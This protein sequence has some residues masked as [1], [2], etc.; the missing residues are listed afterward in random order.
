MPNVSSVDNTVSKTPESIKTK[1]S[2]MYDTQRRA[3]N[4]DTSDSP[5]SIFQIKKL[6]NR[7]T[8]SQ[9]R[10]TALKYYPQLNRTT[11]SQIRTTESKHY[12]EVNRGTM[13]QMQSTA[14]KHY[15][16]MNRATM[17]QKRGIVSKHN[18]GVNGSKSQISLTPSKRCPEVNQVTKSQIPVIKPKHY[19][20]VT[21]KRGVCH[22]CNG[23]TRERC[24][25]CQFYLCLSN[26]SCFLD[27]HFGKPMHFADHVG[28]KSVMLCKNCNERK[29]KYRC[30]QCLNQINGKEAYFCITAKRNCFQEFHKSNNL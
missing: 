18:P 27:F 19:P 2:R 20:E 15:P 12:T 28:P 17:S 25:I 23:L 10:V 1:I 14:S 13:S 16:D 8:T 9:L 11:M 30:V 24:T 26:K 29:A 22:S 3:Y 6:E 21:G 7:A 5:Q 4:A